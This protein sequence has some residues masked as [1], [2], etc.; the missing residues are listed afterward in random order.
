MLM[1]LT[2]KN[3]IV[4]LLQILIN[5]VLL[6]NFVITSKELSLKINLKLNNYKLHHHQLVNQFKFISLISN[7][8]IISSS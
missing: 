3:N 2:I 8:K 7:Q 6:F 1:I 4:G 5:M